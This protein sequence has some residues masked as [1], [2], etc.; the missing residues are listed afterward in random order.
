VGRATTHAASE[1]HRLAVAAAVAVV[2][3]AAAAAAATRT[4]ATLSVPRTRLHSRT[5]RA[6]DRVQD[7]VDQVEGHVPGRV[8]HVH[9]QRVVLLNSGSP[10]VAATPAIPRCSCNHNHQGS[11]PGRHFRA[12]AAIDP[13]WSVVRSLPAHTFVRVPVRHTSP[14]TRTQLSVGASASR[15]PE[16]VRS[17]ATRPRAFA[18][19]DAQTPHDYLIPSSAG[20]VAATTTCA[21]LSGALRQ[22]SLE[23]VPSS[24]QRGWSGHT[25]LVGPGWACCH[26]RGASSS[27]PWRRP[28]RCRR[29]VRGDGG[30]ARVAVARVIM[31]A[32]TIR[33]RCR[34]VLEGQSLQVSPLRALPRNVIHKLSSTLKP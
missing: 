25:A 20:S 9:V 14:R 34:R 33:H 30:S 22:N 2:V 11:S 8:V 31:V 28:W 29:R 10:M 3:V 4:C 18:H 32:V 27:S 23:P 13:A 26:C 7:H 1:L 21:N 5:L 6:P 19:M 16:A 17:E 15:G 12:W 24:S